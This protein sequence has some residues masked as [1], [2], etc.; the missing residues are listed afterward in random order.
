MGK[1]R[2]VIKMKGTMAN[3]TFAKTTDD[4]I[5]KE[6]TEI[7]KQRILTDPAYQRTRETMA[8]FGNAGKAAKL[9]RAALS[10]VLPPT[11]DK[12]LTARLQRLLFR[13]VRTDADNPRGSRQVWFGDLKILNGFEF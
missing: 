7:S 9:M 13:V 6:K 1:L 5:V 11:R 8:E 4:I 12:R 3:V 2:G 10:P